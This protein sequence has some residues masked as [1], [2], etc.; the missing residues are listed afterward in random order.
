MAVSK[1]TLSTDHVLRGLDELRNQALLC[2]VHLVAEGAKFPVHRVVLAAASPY[3]QAMFTGGFKEN[4][5]SEITLNDVSSKGLECALDAIYTAEL[6]L[7]WENVCDVLP[8][9]SLLQL[10]EII[11]HCGRFLTRNISIHNCICILSVAEKYDLQEVV[12]QCNKF[13]LENFDTVSQSVEFT[14]ITKEQLCSYL[15]DNQLKAGNGEIEVFRASLRW[16]KANGTKRFSGDCTYLAQLMQYVRFPLIPSDLLLDKVLTN[17]LISEN[18]QMKGMVEEAL[19]FHNDDNTFLQPLQEG[20]QFQ[21]RGEQMLALIQ[22]TGRCENHSLE[23]DKTKLH[24]IRGTGDAPFHS[25]FFEQELPI[26]LCPHSL[27]LATKGN[28]LFLFGVDVEDWREIALWF[29]VRT[30]TWL[31]L[32]SPPCHIS[33]GTGATL[34]NDS[35]YVFGGA[36]ISKEIR[37]YF[38]F[39]NSGNG[40]NCI[41]GDFSAHASKYS[42]ETNSWSQLEDLPTALSYHSAAAHGN[43]VFCAGGFLVGRCIP[44]R[45]VCPSSKLYAFDVEDKSWVSK[46]SMHNK[47]ANFSLEVLGPKLVACGGLTVW[48]HCTDR[49]K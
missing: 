12:D 7:C 33:I 41:E 37:G 27:A 10:N 22:S 14:S 42:I 8:V 23:V 11:E 45:I 21:P 24:L 1:M 49:L 5:M 13:I 16:I 2:D 18:P 40:W 44:M 25:Q 30:N 47:R 43:N 9:A 17:S 19:K 4:H 34:L 39:L 3:F 28:Y 26:T 48:P 46:A 29:D 15:S 36:T 38:T 20:K 6:S 31:D 35:I 32:E